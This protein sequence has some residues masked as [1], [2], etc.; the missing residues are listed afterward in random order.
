MAVMTKACA[1]G[2]VGFLFLSSSVNAWSSRMRNPRWAA[3]KIKEHSPIKWAATG[4]LAISLAFGPLAPAIANEGA[5]ETRTEP[6]TGVNIE[7]ETKPLETTND[8]LLKTISDAAKDLFKASDQEVDD[9]RGKAKEA[10]PAPIQDE[11]TQATNKVNTAPVE[12]KTI[13]ESKAEKEPVNEAPVEKVV[14]EAK[15][16]A[17]EQIDE[18]KNNE[19]VEAPVV[20]EEAT[21]A[22]KEVPAAKVEKEPAEEVPVEKSVAE[23]KAVGEQKAQAKEQVVEPKADKEVEAPVVVKEPFKAIKEVPPG[24]VEKEPVREEPTDRAV[25]DPKAQAKEQMHERKTDEQVEAPRVVKDE[26]K[27]LKETPAEVV[28]TEPEPEE[29]A[30]KPAEVTEKIQKKAPIPAAVVEDE[31]PK[32]P[33][34]EPAKPEA[35]RSEV[36]EPPIVPLYA[37]PEEEPKGLGDRIKDFIFLKEHEETPRLFSGVD[38]SSILDRHISTIT[39]PAAVTGEELTFDVTIRDVSLG[40]AVGVVAVYWGAYA[41]YEYEGAQEELQAQAKRKA[42]AAKRKAA[43]AK[44]KVVD[45]KQAD[46]KRKSTAPRA[47][48]VA[49]TVQA[50]SATPTTTVVR[51]A[52]GPQNGAATTFGARAATSFG[53]REVEPRPVGVGAGASYL[54]SLKKTAAAEAGDESLPTQVASAL[55]ATATA[56]NEFVGNGSENGSVTPSEAGNVEAHRRPDGIGAGSSY[57]DS[58][59]RH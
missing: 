15:T 59:S 19:Q 16:E 41:Y 29:S 43:A 50:E 9:A 13:E 47:A 35:G 46:T 2:A 56:T 37:P 39:L 34:E 57:L 3:P 17:K 30:E 36:K 14:E 1:I 25:E 38:R 48:E 12:E 27:T 53:A 32:A 23:Q 33:A 5:T 51:A 18:P 55:E 26:K 40:S 10:G 54:D 28:T 8:K 49:P 52:N 22:V 45:D 31:A 42:M 11:T 7:A 21:K 20:V 4:F 6:P 58:L 24:K 44:E